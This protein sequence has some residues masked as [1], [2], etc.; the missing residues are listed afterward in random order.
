MKFVENFGLATHTH[1]HVYMS[2]SLYM[3][4]GYFLYA[5]V[6]DV[7]ASVYINGPGEDLAATVTSTLLLPVAD[8][9]G[10]YRVGQSGNGEYSPATGLGV[11]MQCE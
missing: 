3:C 9:A 2:T 5:Q 1:R 11:K 8:G 4:M 10:S 7:A 6:H